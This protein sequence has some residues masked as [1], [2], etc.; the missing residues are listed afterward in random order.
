MHG[1][2]LSGLPNHQR[3]KGADEQS[4]DFV[5][6]SLMF[7][8]SLVGRGG[9]SFRWETGRPHILHCNTIEA[10]FFRN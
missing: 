7:T 4:T 5:S 1:G 9:G 6:T 10:T 3:Y 8:L 2:I